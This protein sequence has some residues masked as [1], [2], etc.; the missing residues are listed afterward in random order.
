[1]KKKFKNYHKIPESEY[2]DIWDN[3][4]FILDTNI[5]LNLFRYPENARVDFL[6]VLKK[7]KSRIWVPFIAG[8]EF[9]ENLE[10]VKNSQM[11]AYDKI[12]NLIDKTKLKELLLK[13]ELIS[14]L[15]K[16]KLEKRH[17]DISEEQLISDFEQLSNDYQEKIS[18]IQKKYLFDEKS[19]RKQKIIKENS[20][21]LE[22]L[23]KLL[24]KKIGDPFDDQ[25]A[26]SKINKEGKTRFENLIPPGFK[27]SSKERDSNKRNLTFNSL[28]YKRE[29]C[30]LYIWNEIINKSNSLDKK[31]SNVVFITDDAKEDWWRIVNGKTVGPRIELI[32]E[33]KTKT[34]GKIANFLMYNSWRFLEY[35][36]D[37]YKIAL[38]SETLPQ[39]RKVQE[40]RNFILK[41]RDEIYIAFRKYLN[42]INSHVEFVPS[43]AKHLIIMKDEVLDLIAFDVRTK[44]SISFNIDMVIKDV[45]KK[46]DSGI[47]DKYYSYN[48]V[49]IEFD[50][51]EY[52]TNRFIYPS[53]SEKLPSKIN[54]VSNYV[55]FDEVKKEYVIE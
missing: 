15:K 35:A 26:I 52:E 38:K 43:Q 3:A 30:D 54:I 8:L 36:T 47:L 28:I 48:I 44:H 4:I 49:I 42:K 34:N 33:L 55:D 46:F 40:N 5:L 10:H 20:K 24:E 18:V 2:S 41:Y 6:K 16:F 17:Y 11:R 1:M 9:Y 39:I 31:T 27:D 53:Y 13:D 45:I 37:K 19:E 51:E 32:D 14:D 50:R 22:D 7:I 23:E 25:D 12:Y 29:F 21:L